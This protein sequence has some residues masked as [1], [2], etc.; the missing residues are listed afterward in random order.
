MQ[1]L[2]LFIYELLLMTDVRRALLCCVLL[3]R[4]L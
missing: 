2:R 4:C 1:R 3:T